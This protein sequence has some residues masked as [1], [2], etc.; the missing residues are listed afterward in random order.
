MF[1]MKRQDKNKQDRRENTEEGQRGNEEK[2]TLGRTKN[3]EDDMLG[4]QKY[5]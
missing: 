4:Q 5:V 2:L 1:V 3:R